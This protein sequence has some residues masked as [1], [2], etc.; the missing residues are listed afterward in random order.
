MKMKN[1]IAVAILL[2][3]GMTT[4]A[5]FYIGSGENIHVVNGGLLYTNDNVSGTGS[6]NVNLS[7]T[8][9][10][11]SISGVTINAI[12]GTMK[13]SGS[14]DQVV[15]GARFVDNAINRLFNHNSTSI[16]IDGKVIVSDTLFMSTTGTP[17]VKMPNG[18]TLLLA[19]VV[20]NGG[21]FQINGGVLHLNPNALDYACTTKIIG[22]S[23]VFSTVNI[24]ENRDVTFGTFDLVSVSTFNLETVNNHI[25]RFANSSAVSWAGTQLTING[26]QGAYDGTSGTIGKIY[27]GSSAAA[28]TAAQLEKI[29]FYDGT[30]YYDATLL[31]T[32]ELV[33]AANT[34]TT[35]SVATTICPGAGAT[36]IPFTYTNEASF[37]S[38]TTFTVQLSDASGSFTS[39]TTLGTVT[40]D[41]TGSQSLSYN[42]TTSNIT[43]GSGYRIRVISDAPVLSGSDNGS[44]I[45]FQQVNTYYLDADGDTYGAAG[46]SVSDCSQPTGY[47]SDNTDCDDSNNAIYPGATETCNSVDDDCDTSIDEGVQTTFYADADNDTYGDL[48]TTTAACSAPAGYVSNSTDCNDASASVNP[49]ATETCNSVDDDCD[50]SIDEGVQTTFYADADNDTYGDLATTTAACSAPAGYVSNSTD[51]NDASASVNPG[52]TETCNS[53]DDDCDTSIDEGVQTT[54]YAD[55]DNDTYGDL[56]TTTAACSAPAGYVSNSTDCNDASASVNPGATET[57]NSVDDD[58]DTSIDEGV[59]TTF[60]ADADNDTYGDLTTTTAACSAPAGFV[61][62]STDCNDASASVNPGATE[63]CNSVDDDCDTSIDEGVQT[64]FYAD[65]DN[66]TYGDLATT[67]AACSA[68]AGYVSNSTDCNDASASVN[69]GATETCNS[70]D[71]DCDTS[72][73]EGVQTTFYADADNDTYGDLATTTAACSAPAGYVSNSTDCNDASASV[74]PGATETCNNVD[75]DCDGSTDEGVQTT[76]YA[77]ADNDT[78]GDLAT[79]TAACSVPVGFVSNSTDCNDASA[80]VNPAATETCNNVDDDCDGTTDEGVQTTFYADADNDTYGDLATTTAACSVPVGFVSNSTDCNDASASVYPGATET[81]NSVDDDCDTS[82]DEG[83]QTTFYADADNDTYGDLATTTAACTA[84]AGFVSNSTDCNDADNAVNPGA[85]EVCGG[86]DEDCDGQQNEGLTFYNYYADNDGD[87]YAGTLVGN[88]CFTPSFAGYS[89]TQDDCDDTNNAINP[90]ATESCNAIDDNCSGTT[91]EGVTTTYYEDNDND[92]Y[93]SATSTVQACSLPS[94]YVTNSSDCNDNNGSVNPAATELCGNSIDEDCSGSDLVCPD[95][96]PGSALLLANIGFY[97]ASSPSISVNLP[98]GTNSVENPGDGQDRWFKFVAQYNAIRVALTGSNAVTDDNDI[99]LF[100]D[101]TQLGVQLIPVSSENAVS[102]VATGAALD[103]GSETLIF[104]QLV[105]GQTYYICVRNNNNAPGVCAMVCQYLRGSANDLAVVTSNTNTF[106]NSC[107]NFK[108]VYRFGASSYSIKRWTGASATGEAEF[109]YANSTQVGGVTSSFCQLGKFVV[110]NLTNAPIQYTTKVD[111]IYN[112][113]DAFG[114]AEVAV[115]DGVIAATFT[116][117]PELDLNVRTTDRCPVYKSATAGSL[118]TNRSICG[119]SRYEWEFT[120]TLPTP[121]LPVNELGAVGGSRI[122]M[123]SQ[124]DGILGGQTY[125]VKIRSKHFDGAS[126]TSYGTSQCVRTLGIAGMPTTDEESSEISDN[127]MKAVLYPNPNAGQGFTL[128]VEGMD[129]DVV[130]NVTDATGKLVKA[131]RYV[132]DGGFTAEV[133]FAQALASGLYQVEI[134]NGTSRHTMR[135]AV[136]R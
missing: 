115:G 39:A 97:G 57:C 38:S 28:L 61:S 22:D 67:T 81:C 17:V 107:Q 94:G 20:A 59:Q 99:N 113:M 68:P 71:D 37:G 74:N 16:T 69:P 42:F 117:A 103:A 84:P 101:P 122:M 133:E 78:Y 124:V 44:D 110:A 131:M 88:N 80:S 127:G 8:E 121:S 45:T 72:I 32:G 30:Y 36:S 47:V 9:A 135:M 46:S 62:N 10:K 73:D 33:P 6:I 86:T 7:T 53:V 1:T 92:T 64:T 95:G 52:A 120:Q 130:V 111:V 50:T 132:A 2:L 48:A 12:N 93:G 54:F 89:G 14:A 31:S 4:K 24:I 134:M 123:M 70:V 100:N 104:D 129:G 83:V 105:P 108:S 66:D 63:T 51:C 43:A 29:R 109:T 136:N 18:D 98:V 26:W 114:N 79:T 102:T 126:N 3:F 60:Y 91:D 15:N 125:G 27:F 23:G 13:M 11:G 87:T 34:I 77:D 65:A 40:G 49:G 116:L 96:G 90:G 55:A 82:I 25:I 19:A 75:D 85:I 119:T 56:A 5:Q 21:E 76:Y 118:A 58:C 106:S 112:L 41:A 35:G 128:N